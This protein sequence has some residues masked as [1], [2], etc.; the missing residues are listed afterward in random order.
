MA[1]PSIYRLA[2]EPFHWVDAALL[3]AGI[4]LSAFHVIRLVRLNRM[5]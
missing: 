3:A 5:R 1:I 2:T 4:G